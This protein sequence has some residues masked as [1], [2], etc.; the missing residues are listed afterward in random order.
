MPGT[1]C[2]IGRYLFIYSWQQ[3]CLGLEIRQFKPKMIM[4]AMQLENNVARM[5]ILI[6]RPL[7]PKGILNGSVISDFNPYLYPR[8][9]DGARLLDSRQYYYSYYSPSIKFS[10]ISKTG[11]YGFCLFSCFLAILTKPTHSCFNPFFKFIFFHDAL[12][13]WPC[14]FTLVFKSLSILES[15]HWC[16]TCFRCLCVCCPCFSFVYSYGVIHP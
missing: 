13:H 16:S 3:P 7:K 9:P 12:H 6:P 5:C 8:G 2:L 4:W 15:H 14:Q 10:W 11:S 1:V